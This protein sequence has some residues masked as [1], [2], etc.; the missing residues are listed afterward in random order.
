M[1]NIM[2][3][4]IRVLVM[5]VALIIFLIGFISGYWLICGII[6][7]GLLCVFFLLYS[8]R[9]QRVCY[10]IQGY[11]KYLRENGNDKRGAIVA[12]QK[13]FCSG[14]YADE[15]ICS[16]SYQEI[17]ALVMDIIVKEFKFE[18]LM[19]LSSDSEDEVHDDMVRYQKEL[20]TLQKEIADVKK[21]I[22]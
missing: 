13:E 17:D 22:L 11:K 2:K 3:N 7:V 8:G 18:N 14:K 1:G 19:R 10:W 5:P 16:K 9:K 12:I 4:I 21:E 15:D 6:G 20:Q